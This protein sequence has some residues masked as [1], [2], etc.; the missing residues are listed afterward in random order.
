MKTL[1]EVK[2]YLEENTTLKKIIIK[3]NHRYGR[4]LW[5]YK[6]EPE[7]KYK[8]YSLNRKTG[9]VKLKNRYENLACI[10]VNEKEIDLDVIKQDIIHNNLTK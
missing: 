6:Y 10:I 5:G 7:F 1:Q 4:T 3:R 2:K 9:V 8:Y